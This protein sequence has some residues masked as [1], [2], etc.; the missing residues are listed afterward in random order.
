MNELKSPKLR[1]V[2][3]YKPDYPLGQFPAGFAMELGKELI[4]LLA[5]R[6][7]PTLEGSDWEQIFARC[8]GAQWAPSNV[9][10]DDVQ[11][12]QMAWSAKTVKNKNPFKVK[13]V[14]LISG[15]NSPDYSFDIENVHTEDPDKLGEMI[16][17]IWNARITDVR[18]KFA[19]TRTVVLVKGDD[20][21]TVSVF[22]E[23]A[24]KFLPEDYEWE[25]NQKGNLEGYLKGSDVKKFT[26]QPHGSQFTIT[27]VVPDNRLKL[28]IRRPPLLDRDEVLTQLKFDPSWV[29]IVK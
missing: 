13:H 17:D 29:E 1:G 15:R 6:N 25:W 9:G 19:T 21:S 27:T 23:D 24:L 10:L 28:R 2:D 18:K 14:R 7:P 20:L 5:T 12:H 4:Y 11:L 3:K 8:V 22:E 16:L 26:W